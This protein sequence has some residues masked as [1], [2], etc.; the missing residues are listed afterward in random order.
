MKW[1][2]AGVTLLACQEG[3][4]QSVSTVSQKVHAFLN[5]CNNKYPYVNQR[6]E[7]ELLDLSR[8]LDGAPAAVPALSLE[9]VK[10]LLRWCITE[11]SPLQ[12][13]RRDNARALWRE[14]FAGDI[15]EYYQW[16]PQRKAYREDKAS[17]ER[18]IQMQISGRTF[19]AE[20][21]R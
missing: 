15:P 16:D 18:W 4:S 20:E 6:L 19:S 8:D 5:G 3:A 11:G 14:L 12:D 10:R 13:F 7:R 9:S 21:S 2:R 1:N 17:R